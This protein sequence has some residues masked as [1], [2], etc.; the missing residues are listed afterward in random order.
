MRLSD[1]SAN[2]KKLL[3]GLALVL[4]AGGIGFAVHHAR[5]TAEVRLPGDDETLAE[6]G[7]SR[8]TRYDLDRSIAST[9]S[10]AAA[11]Q[12]DEHGRREMLKSLVASRAIAEARERELDAEQ[13]EEL[14]RKVE[15]YREQ[16]LVRDYLEAHATPQPVTPEM[17]RT[18]YEEHPERFGGGTTREYEML[19]TTR[20]L[21]PA[22]RDTLLRALGN[23]GAQSDW[24]A[25]A[26]TLASQGLPVTHQRGTLA[27]SLLD[28]RLRRVLEG[29]GVN[30]ASTV[31]LIDGKAYLLRVTGETRRPPRPL[32]EV[33]AE[34]RTTLAPIQLRESVRRVR[35]QVLSRT[36]VTYR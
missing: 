31:T 2:Q 6:V 34:I 22:E 25:W 13:R 33:S 3:G 8:I 24:A 32:E 4:V 17:V 14:A 29:L 30:Q 23:P 28:E 19:L 26:S 21:T 7:E 16:L 15:A 5:S 10:D 27:A 9:L 36:H 18:Y 12:L 35:E 1:L 20:A 11:A